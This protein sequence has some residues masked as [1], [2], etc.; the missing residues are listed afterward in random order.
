[1][2]SLIIM[3]VLLLPVY[4]F[5]QKNVERNDFKKYFDEYGHD[6]CF[7]LYDLNKDFYLKFN[8]ERCSERF[9]P[10]STFK[11]FNSLLNSK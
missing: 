6:G 2:K 1:M 8:P 3:F 7:V 5:S 4:N 9:I 11:I 10:A